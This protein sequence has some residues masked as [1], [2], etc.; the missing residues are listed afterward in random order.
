MFICAACILMSGCARI[1]NRNAKIPAVVDG[2][3]IDMRFGI[4]R[5]M[6][7]N[8]KIDKARMAYMEI[9]EQIPDH[10]E[11]LHRV[12]VSLVYQERIAESLIY[13][14]KAS[15]VKTPSAELLGD[16]GFAQH[17]AGDNESA[18]ISLRKA[19]QISP[20][21]QRAINNLAIVLGEENRL[22][23]AYEL[24]RRVNSEAEAIAN[25]AFVQVQL[26]KLKEAKASYHR[27]LEL[28]P[29]LEIAAMGLLEL[30]VKTKLSESTGLHEQKVLATVV[31]QSEKQKPESPVVVV[32]DANRKPGE[33]ILNASKQAEIEFVQLISD[34]SGID[35]TDDTKAEQTKSP[36]NKKT[37]PDT[38]SVSR[39]SEDSAFA[40]EFKIFR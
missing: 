24:F 20:N 36:I 25:L 23:E 3:E 37:E 1:Q 19:I 35:K 4:A 17:L 39:D 8:G 21:E 40:D 13:F 10:Y 2:K 33:V 7:R 5:L 18:E 29:S 26:G 15:K 9:L 11:S 30:H 28:K 27:A 31:S 22:N 32:E 16:W 6:E 12:A 34:E 14:E 38:D